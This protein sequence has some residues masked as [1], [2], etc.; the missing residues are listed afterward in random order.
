MSNLLTPTE[1]ADDLRIKPW[2]VLR[3]IR[4]GDLRA[5]KFGQSWRIEAAD[6]EAFKKASCNQRAAS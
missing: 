1:V 6:F 2:T 5:Y 3:L 4:N